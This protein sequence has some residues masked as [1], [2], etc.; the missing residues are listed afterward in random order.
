MRDY[1]GE[2]PL[3]AGPDCQHLNDARV[4]TMEELAGVLLSSENVHF[5]SRLRNKM[6]SVSSAVSCRPG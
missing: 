5:R 4:M 6:G 3:S 2:F 1:L